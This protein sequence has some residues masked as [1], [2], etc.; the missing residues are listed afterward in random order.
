MDAL[1]IA[2]TVAAQDL[3]ARYA[4]HIDRRDFAGFGD[5]FAEDAAFALGP[6]ACRGRDA[7]RQFMAERLTAPGGAHVI[8]NISARSDGPDRTTVLADYVLTRRT[9]EAGP[10]AIVGAG[11]YESTLVCADGEWQFQEHRITSR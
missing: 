1:D 3:L 11:Y 5:L 10:W 9:E 2:T 6:D 7:I 4:H 8:V